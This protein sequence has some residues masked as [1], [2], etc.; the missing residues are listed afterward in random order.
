M[1]QALLPVHEAVTR[2]RHSTEALTFYQFSVSLSH[3]YSKMPGQERHD[4]YAA[5]LTNSCMQ[6]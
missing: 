4:T 3:C 2:A 5:Q 1:L 6:S